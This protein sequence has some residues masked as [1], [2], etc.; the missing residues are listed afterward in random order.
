M[1]SVSSKDTEYLLRIKIYF[2]I[3]QD[4]PA[5]FITSNVSFLIYYFKSSNSLI[6]SICYIQE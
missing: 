3:Q 1:P 5:I 4:F 2:Y 6:V